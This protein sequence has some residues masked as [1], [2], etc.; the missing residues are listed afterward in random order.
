[1]QEPD[2]LDREP[3]YCNRPD[4]HFDPPVYID[5]DLEGNNQVDVSASQSDPPEGV[6]DRDGLDFSGYEEMEPLPSF[7]VNGSDFVGSWNGFY[8]YGFS[9]STGTDG[10]MGFTPTVPSLVVGV[11]CWPISLLK[12]F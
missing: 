4:S 5:S 9:T 12:G 7:N 2:E 1:M 6:E 10:I 8:Y 11:T 3:S